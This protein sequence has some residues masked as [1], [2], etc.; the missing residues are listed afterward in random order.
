[1]LLLQQSLIIGVNILLQHY[2]M[3]KC[4]NCSYKFDPT[5][6]GNRKKRKCGMCYFGDSYSIRSKKEYDR[7]LLLMMIES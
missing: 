6:E 2:T 3:I 7:N 5:K 4:R 1:M